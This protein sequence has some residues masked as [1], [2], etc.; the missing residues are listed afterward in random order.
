MTKCSSSSFDYHRSFGLLISYWI[1]EL[2]F[3]LFLNL[4]WHFFQFNDNDA[5]DEYIY[6]ILQ[7]F[8]DF[9]SYLELILHIR[10]QK[11]IDSSAITNNDNINNSIANEI[12]K[13]E[14]NGCSCNIKFNLSSIKPILFLI[15]LLDLY[16]RSSFYISYKVIELKNA[17]VSQKLAKDML[18]LLDTVFRIIFSIKINNDESY[19]RSHKIFAI[20][21]IISIMAILIIVDVIHSTFTDEYNLLNCMY[22]FLVLSPRFIFY[23]LVDTLN[24]NY[25]YNKSISPCGYMRRRFAFEF[26]YL[27]II[28]PPLYYS[29]ILHFSSDIFCPRFFLISALYIFCCFVK[30]NLIIN[31]IYYYNTQSVSFLIISESLASSIIEIIDFFKGEENLNDPLNIIIS[32]VEILLIILI[33]IVTMIYEEIIIINICGLNKDLKKEDYQREVNDILDITSEDDKLGKTYTSLNTLH[34]HS[35]SKS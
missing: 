31:V 23:P 10:K 13:N 22:Y 5:D 3:R 19:M 32:F 14:I 28:T 25:M 15:F 18:I 4:G 35:S 6:V 11:Q 29:S 7:N 24:R 16:N 34:P 21:S 33:G 1:F 9:F 27:A 8:S 2:F 30:S 26:I 17:Q 12:N 20:I